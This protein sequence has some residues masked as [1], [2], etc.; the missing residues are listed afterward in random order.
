MELCRI[1]LD[2]YAEQLTYEYFFGLLGQYMCLLKVEYMSYFRTIFYKLCDIDHPFENVKSRNV[3]K[4]FAH[5]LA[6]D[7]ISWDV[8]I[9]S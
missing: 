9:D 3:A 1:V 7:S 5:L 2:S 4:F 6:T 8:C